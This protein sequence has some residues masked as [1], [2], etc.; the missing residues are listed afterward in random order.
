MLRVSRSYGQGG[1]YK[2]RAQAKSPRAQKERKRDYTG[3]Q[4]NTLPRRLEGTKAR[5]KPYIFSFAPSRLCAFVSSW[6]FASLRRETCIVTREQKIL[7][8]FASLH[9]IF[10]RIGAGAPAI[11]PLRSQHTTLVAICPPYFYGFWRKSQKSPARRWMRSRGME[12]RHGLFSWLDADF[13]LN[14][15]RSYAPPRRAQNQ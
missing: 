12:T 5:R 4:Q 13:S 3:I 1:C 2:N 6:L 15:T 9:E 7:A 11:G 8:A 10:V 14:S